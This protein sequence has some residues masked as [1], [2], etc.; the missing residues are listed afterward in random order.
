MNNI[1]MRALYSFLFVFLSI[2]STHA[3]EKINTGEDGNLRKALEQGVRV[4]PVGF[5]MEFGE[6]YVQLSLSDLK[7][8]RNEKVRSGDSDD[9]DEHSSSATYAMANAVVELPFL[10]TQKDGTKTVGFSGEVFFNKENPNQKSRIYLKENTILPFFEKVGNL[11]LVAKPQK[12][13][14]CEIFERSYVEFDCNGIT[15]VYLTGYLEFNKDLLVP[16]V[17]GEVKNEMAKEKDANGNEV[18]PAV[19][20]HQ[21]YETWKEVKNKTVK[22]VFNFHAKHGVVSTLCFNR[23]FKMKKSAKNFV[24]QV[25]DA[26]LDLSTTNN[27]PNFKLPENYMADGLN[28]EEWKGVSLREISV[29]FP[30]DFSL[31]DGAVATSARV[32]NMLIDEYGFTGSMEVENLVQKKFG[33]KAGAGLDLSIDKLAAEV[34]QGRFMKGEIKGGVS[35]PF[36][37]KGANNADAIRAAKYGDSE[38]NAKSDADLKQEEEKY[39]SPELGF[40]AVVSLY[41]DKEYNIS[42]K[43]TIDKTATY[44][45]PFTDKATISI[46]PGSRFE[47]FSGRKA[48]EAQPETNTTA[49]A[50]G[51]TGEDGEVADAAEVDSTR[52]LDFSLVLNGSLDI[53]SSQKT[54]K[55]NAGSK[56]LGFG[57]S[58]QGLPF[59]GLRFSNVGRAVSIAHVGT[60]GEAELKFMALTVTL[61]EIG[62]DDGTDWQ[63]GDGGIEGIPA[64]K[65]GLYFKSSITL[66]GKGGGD[67]GAKF[68]AKFKV[69]NESEKNKWH[70]AGIDVNRIGLK[71]NLGAFS[72]DGYLDLFKDD[73]IF[74]RGFKGQIKMLLVP[75]DSASMEVQC[76]FG[77][78]P[79]KKDHPSYK[80]W[81]TK[82][83]CTF[84]KP[85]LP[86]ACGNLRSLSGGAFYHMDDGTGRNKK[87]MSDEPIDP[88]T[89]AHATGFKRVDVSSYKPSDE[90]GFGIILGMG[91][92][93]GGEN[94]ATLNAEAQMIFSKS[95]AL[96]KFVI[97]GDF[98]LITPAPPFVGHIEDAMKKVEDKM[99]EFTTSS[100]LMTN[101][102]E[103]YL[104]LTDNSEPKGEIPK[105][106]NSIHGWAVAC[107]NHTDKYFVMDAQVIADYG[108]KILYGK[109]D[110]S[111]FV[112]KDKWYL[113]IGTDRDPAY[114]KVLNGLA[115]G[116]TYFMT[117]EL[118]YPD[119]KPLS[120]NAEQ[121]FKNKIVTADQL[122]TED[123]NVPKA[124][125]IAFGVN[126][127]VKADFDNV[128][129]VYAGFYFDGGTDLIMRT[130]NYSYN[131]KCHKWR[132]QGSIYGALGI[133]LGVQWPFPEKKWSV[134]KSDAFFGLRGMAPVPLQGEA[135]MNMHVQ[136]CGFINIWPDVRIRIGN[137]ENVQCGSCS[138]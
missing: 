25:F 27:A 135:V 132:A 16:V 10:P 70:F 23:A 119:I 17:R 72:M 99:K 13:D 30:E 81:F 112:N 42:A 127:Q 14:S 28:E 118:P 104:K 71:A 80:Y 35:V 49:S 24:F 64:T 48:V 8:V 7:F 31:N 65:G 97:G 109:A 85:G 39:P 2:F 86:V 21:S 4:M 33:K 32:Q 61:D 34:Y 124:K 106:S 108:E 138:E 111:M 9:A 40:E 93:F 136:V 84:P 98:T 115:I 57:C 74:G 131:D 11:V 76:A 91:M 113:R 6:V 54:D 129:L 103:Q 67:I 83:S 90:A 18:K 69:Y 102:S 47:I 94:M 44:K 5:E 51:E 107:Y 52:H 114:V 82:A 46:L 120:E 95:F 66:A 29:Y 20:T 134:I 75:L 43:C 121:Q 59:E 117:G 3:F 79:D 133:D 87:E 73:T 15:D 37:R 1:F 78:T 12:V 128:P 77:S 123:T 116:R 53:M 19:N 105:S 55:S 22:A 89:D 50:S 126:A 38:G 63:S 101:L 122:N 45:V 100:K 41:D 58:F 130:C 36:L 56:K 92:N 60:K 62:W 137:R 125:G 88:E 96:D 26:A 110:F 68:G